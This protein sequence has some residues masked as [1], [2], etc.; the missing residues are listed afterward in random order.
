MDLERYTHKALHTKDILLRFPVEPNAEP[1]IFQ[2]RSRLFGKKGQWASV[3]NYQ[4][5]TR[6]KRIV[7]QKWVVNN[8]AIQYKGQG[9]F[10]IESTK[11][12]LYNVHDNLSY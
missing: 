1:G 12:C 4:S 9:K 10:E 3:I 8:Q 6:G 7:K 11:G 2:S 5:R